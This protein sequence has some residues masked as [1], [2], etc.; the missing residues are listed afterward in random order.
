MKNKVQHKKN[1][2]SH[3]CTIHP[4]DR[5]F[6]FGFFPLFFNVGLYTETVTVSSR[7]RVDNDISRMIFYACHVVSH[8]TFI[9]TVVNRVT[10][11]CYI[12]PHLFRF[13]IYI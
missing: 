10:K 4:L 11:L 13:H 6:L 5:L 7:M 8:R 3:S 1:T 12:V 2:S 9:F